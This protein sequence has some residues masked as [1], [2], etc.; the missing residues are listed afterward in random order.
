MW[1]GQYNHIHQRYSEVCTLLDNHKHKQIQTD[2]MIF[3]GCGGVKNAAAGGPIYLFL[4]ACVCRLQSCWKSLLLFGCL[5]TVEKM[6][7]FT[8]F[9]LCSQ[10]VGVSETPFQ[11]EKFSPKTT[12]RTTPLTASAPGS[13]PPILTVSGLVFRWKFTCAGHFPISPW[14][15]TADAEIKAPFC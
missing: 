12:P 5:C 4:C 2:C 9:F 1:H 10:A 8:L 15:G 6:E 13:S 7:K 3:A 11:M 14:W